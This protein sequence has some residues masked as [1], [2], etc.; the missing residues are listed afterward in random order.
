MVAGAIA[1]DLDL[2]SSR[3]LNLA[4]AA[5][6][7]P[8]VLLRTPSPQARVPP[9]RAGASPPHPPPATASAPSPARAGAWRWSAAATAVPANG[10]SS[11]P[12]SRIVSVWLRAWPIARLLRAQACGA[13]ADAVMPEA[14]LRH[15]TGRP[16]VLVAPG[17]GGARIVSLNRAARQG[18]LVE[19]ELAL[20][21]PLQ[22]ARPA[23]ARCRSW[24]RRRSPAQAGAVVPALHADRVAL[25]RDQRCRR[26]VPRHHG[27]RASPRRRGAAA[28]RSGGTLAGVRAL[29]AHGNRRYGRRVLG[30]GASWSQPTRKIVASGGGRQRSRGLAARRAPALGRDPSAPAPARLQAHRRARPISR[31]R[32][33]PRASSPSSCAASIRRWGAHPSRSSPSSRRPSIAP[34]PCSSSRS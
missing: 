27:V 29:P 21:R 32:R 23:V 7:T 24:R 5:H 6:A 28:G 22:G 19:G 15:D 11:G 20:Q 17:K 4:A 12:M 31:A 8:L 3:R 34:R 33:L 14:C 25:G 30:D 10:S 26:P 13:P 2:T 9:P 16:L 18:G 1:G